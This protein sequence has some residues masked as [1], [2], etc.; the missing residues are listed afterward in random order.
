[1]ECNEL[2]MASGARLNGCRGEKPESRSSRVVAALIRGALIALI[3]FPLSAGGTGLYA[4]TLPNAGS[5][6]QQ[7]KE[8][9]PGGLAPTGPPTIEK[10]APPMKETGTVFTVRGFRFTGNEGLATEAQLNGLLKDAIGKKMG[11]Q[12]LK[13]LADRITDYLHRKG[14]FLARAYIPKQQITDGI[15]EIAILAGKVEGNIEIHGKNLRISE[16]RLQNMEEPEVEGQALSQPALQ[17][18]LLLINDLPGVKAGAVI[19]PGDTTGTSKLSVDVSEG[20]LV[21][22]TAQG[23]NYGNPA[24]GTYRGNLAGQLNDPFGYGDQLGLATTDNP[25]YQYGQ[26]SYNIPIGYNGLTAGLSYSEMRY[27]SGDFTALDLNGG[28]RVAGASLAYPLVRSPIANLFAEIQYD[29]TNVWDLSG[30]TSTDNKFLNSGAL[31]FYGDMLD[32]FLGGGYNT[33]SIGFTVG[34]VDLS[35]VPAN[36]IGDQETAKTN[37]VYD[38]ITYS[39]NRI[40]NLYKQLSL[41]LS[42]NG[43]FAF[44]NLDSSEQFFLG[45]PYQVRAYPTGEAMGDSGVVFTTELRYNLP[46]IKRLGFLQ[47]VSFYDLGWI[48]LHQD[49]WAN[50]GT[51]FGAHDSYTLSGAGIGLNLV[52]TGVYTIHT[53]WAHEIGGNPG[54]SLAGLN[55]AGSS[56]GNTFWIAATIIF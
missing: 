12:G 25:N 26:A 3:L 13:R 11:L 45:G 31:R 6:L 48:Q 41:Y 10:E 49:A 54:R 14:W 24:T 39:A 2:F 7:Q 16:D 15:V 9:E 18:S 44:Q 17:R 42:V 29:F 19:Q 40:Q 8:T 34:S 21:T 27:V 56:N 33:G 52:K 53:A 32:T 36:L 30:D 28:A 22:A 50:S 20:P 55:S 47:L 4:Q 38:K 46:A 1:M 37:G 35:A 23:D 43:Q 51:A 5:L